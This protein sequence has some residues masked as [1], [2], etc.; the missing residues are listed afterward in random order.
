MERLLS[1]VV[2]WLLEE[3]GPMERKMQGFRVLSDLVER[4]KNRVWLGHVLL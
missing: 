3:R 2:G 1:K 4:S